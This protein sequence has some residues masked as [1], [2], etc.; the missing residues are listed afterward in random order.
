MCGARCV[1]YMCPGIENVDALVHRLTYVMMRACGPV[2]LPERR[3]H[4]E[5]VDALE[6]LDD[7]GL[8]IARIGR[9]ERTTSLGRGDE[10]TEGTGACLSGSA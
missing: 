6:Y 9:V 1:R 7:L 8:E 10:V 2:I 3:I 5:V 4:D